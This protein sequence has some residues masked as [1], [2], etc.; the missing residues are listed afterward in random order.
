M[1]DRDNIIEN[2]FYQRGTADSTKQAYKIQIKKYEDFTGYSIDQLINI[3][4]EDEKNNIRWKNTKTREFLVNYRKQLYEEYSINSAKLYFSRILTFYRHYEIEIPKL[5]YISTKNSR[6]YS[7][8]T[9]N[10]LPDRDVLQQALNIAPQKLKPLI[11]FLSSSG[12]SRIDACNITIQDYLSA[13]KEYHNSTNI[14]DAISEMH[15][16]DVIPTFFLIR[17]KTK[18]DYFTFCS[19]EAVESINTYLLTRED[20]L[21]DESK[22]FN[23]NYGHIGKSFI[24]INN[25]L[26]LGTV[27]P[28][29]RIRAHML[30]KYHASRL[31]E[32]GLSTDKINLLQ[33]RKVQ[34]IAHESYI[35]VKPTTLK[36]EYIKALPYLVVSDVNKF[37]TK[38]E[39]TREEL[40]S[41]K[42]ENHELKNTIHEEA[43]KAVEEILTQYKNIS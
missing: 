9:F 39:Q 1:K 16:K 25:K 40:T 41:V 31:A 35:R 5:P 21:N 11:L 22:L 14:Y 33:G 26:G 32:A 24:Y 30:R 27:G 19:H 29:N 10:H 37:K 28:Y 8:I 36:E 7:S 42:K 23:I 43:A 17:Q 34:G 18:Q 15:N 2:F 38:L 13:T 6:H 4:D 12:V 20:K 3:A